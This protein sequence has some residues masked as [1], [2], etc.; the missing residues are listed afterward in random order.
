MILERDRQA[1]PS[2]DAGA[3]RAPKPDFRNR[4]L[5]AADQDDNQRSGD[6]I[7]LSEFP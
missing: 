5:E 1:R 6:Q 4:R 3:H 2:E 7:F